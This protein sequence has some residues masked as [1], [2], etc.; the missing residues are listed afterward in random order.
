MND[1]IMPLLPFILFIV[2]FAVLL[3]FL[4]SKKIERDRVKTGYKRYDWLTFLACVL[5]GVLLSSALREAGADFH[6]L[7]VIISAAITIAFIVLVVYKLIRRLKTGR[8][9]GKIISDERTELVMAKSARNA[10]FITCVSLFIFQ[11]IGTETIADAHRMLIMLGSGLGVL[12]I[13]LLYYYYAQ[14]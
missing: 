7:A 6:D 10:F 5:G 8:P 12:M 14:G 2:L 4:F 1:V 11:V 9:V 13:S 3:V